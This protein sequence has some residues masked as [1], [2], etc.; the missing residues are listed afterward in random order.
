MGSD[1]FSSWSLY[2][3]YPITIDKFAAFLIA[4]QWNVRQTMIAPEIILFILVGYGRSFLLSVAWF[5]GA[6]LMI[7]FCFRFPV[8]LLT[9]K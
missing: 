6:Q 2:T 9:P 4:C 3:V 1:C 7:F 8:V 5:I